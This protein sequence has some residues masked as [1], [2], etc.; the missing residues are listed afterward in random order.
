MTPPEGSKNTWTYFQISGK[1]WKPVEL[2][3][4][5][6]SVWADLPKH[7][8]TAGLEPVLNRVLEPTNMSHDTAPEACTLSQGV[9]QNQQYVTLYVTLILAGVRVECSG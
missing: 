1:N 2:S 6:Q 4:F 8:D 5:I 3:R 9:E 7:Q